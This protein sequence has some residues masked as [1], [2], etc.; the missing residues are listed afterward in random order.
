[1]KGI[2]RTGDT[3]AIVDHN[4]VAYRGGVDLRNLHDRRIPPLPAYLT[5]LFLAIGGEATWWLRLPF[6]ICGLLCVALMAR[7]L[8]RAQADRLTWALMSLAIVG[9]VAFI[10]Y[11][12]Q[13][14]YYAPAI[15]ATIGIVYLYLHWNGRRRGLV[16]VAL[17]S[18]VLLACNYLNF[19]VLYICLAVDYWF[20][21]RHRRPLRPADWLTLL[22]PQMVAG[23]VIVGIWNPLQTE[24]AG[25]LLTT[26]LSK[27]LELIGWN[28]RDLNEGELGVGSLLL[29][30]PLLYW[31]RGNVWLLRGWVALLVYV[32]TTGLLSP[33]VLDGSAQFADVRYLAPVIPLC[34]VLGVLGIRELT[35]N[36]QWAALPLGVVAFGSNLLNGGPLL[37]D[38]ARS[39]MVLFVRELLDPPSD[40][41]TVTARWLREHAPD[42]ATVWVLPNESTY[43]LMFHA[44]HLVY[45]W[46]L[47]PVRA[48]QF[49]SLGPIHFQRVV[50]P[51]F[52]VAFGPFVRQMQQVLGSWEVP[53]RYERVARIDH[54]WRDGHRPELFWRTFKPVVR[55]DPEREA[56]YVYQLRG[57]AQSAAARRVL[58]DLLAFQGKYRDAILYYRAALEES[59]DSVETLNNLAWLLATCADET[60]RDGPEAMSLAERANELAG[61]RDPYVW[62]TLAAA[63][64]EAKQF[65]AAVEAAERALA[66]ARQHGN[67]R[68][69]EE[70][71][72]RLALYRAGKPWHEPAP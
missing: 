27:R 17:L 39:T 43:P 32:V 49:R 11:G 14:R 62:G 63:C 44:P 72:Q 22:L 12:R 19:V 30:A 23:G 5:A 20:W 48:R 61:G 25:A 65:D 24:N 54:Y 66:L 64:A 67:A 57:G 16:G 71:V 18:V 55:F 60:L 38:G 34:M 50:P 40:P 26:P 42:R 37:P 53:A 70:T 46:Q 35:R 33:Q 47:E 58:A 15:L 31:W 51:D 68:L 45:A 59:P 6:A 29:L 21:G 52:I 7:W 8:W 36:A 41:F 9:N 13:C 1:A 69:A 3:T 28:F 2:L 4:V 56:I 10:L